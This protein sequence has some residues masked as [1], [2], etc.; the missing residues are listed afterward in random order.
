MLEILDGNGLGKGTR[1]TVG[2]AAGVGGKGL[3]VDVF[4]TTGMGTDV[5]VATGAEVGCAPHA[6]RKN[7]S[8]SRVIF[9]M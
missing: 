3:G 8:K 9:F 5:S 1:V 4:S 6:V 7:I 2:G